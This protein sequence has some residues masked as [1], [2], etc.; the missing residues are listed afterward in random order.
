MERE[1]DYDSKDSFEKE[2]LEGLNMISRLTAN[3]DRTMLA[4]AKNPALWPAQ[5][6]SPH[7]TAQPTSARG[8]RQPETGWAQQAALKQPDTYTSDGHLGLHA[9]VHANQTQRAV[10]LG[11][12]RR[13]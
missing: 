13:P 5:H 10:E 11:A 3:A 4:Q 2:E 12:P 7:N 9:A 1:R 6:S 8:Q